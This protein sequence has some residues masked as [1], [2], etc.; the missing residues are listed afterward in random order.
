MN[1]TASSDDEENQETST[2]E[3]FETENLSTGMGDGQDIIKHRILKNSELKNDSEASLS[4]S[5][6]TSS[7]VKANNISRHKGHVIIPLLPS[8]ITSVPNNIET[9]PY[10]VPEISRNFGKSISEQNFDGDSFEHVEH[11]WSFTAAA[12]QNRERSRQEWEVDTS[13]SE[14]DEDSLIFLRNKKESILLEEEHKRDCT[15]DKDFSDLTRDPLQE[16]WG[17]CGFVAE[18]HH[19]SPNIFDDTPNTGYIRISV[20]LTA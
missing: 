18:N 7:V 19:Q 14:D 4:E 6:A 8:P 9:S 20:C 17:P 3:S 12:I 2:T 11:K 10:S 15:K 16:G 1:E 13:S 5:V